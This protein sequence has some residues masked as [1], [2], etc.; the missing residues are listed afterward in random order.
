MLISVVSFAGNTDHQKAANARQAP[1]IPAV[2]QNI[3]FW[4][5]SAEKL[6][7]FWIEGE[8]NETAG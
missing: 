7:I 2:I 3:Q 5:K 1:N 8:A 6:R 4:I